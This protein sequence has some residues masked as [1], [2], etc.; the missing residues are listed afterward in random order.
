MPYPDEAYR[1]WEAPEINDWE[2]DFD[3]RDDLNTRN[4]RC[5]PLG[6]VLIA[7]TG[8]YLCHP[9]HWCYPRTG[10]YPTNCSPYIACSPTYICYPRR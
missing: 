9:R 6:A 10:C 1:R 5:L 7:A 4:D 8:A 3:Y 2:E